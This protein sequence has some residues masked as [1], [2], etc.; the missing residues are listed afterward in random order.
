MPL[1]T[2]AQR[3]DL[4]E[5][6]LRVAVLLVAC[7]LVLANCA[8]QATVATSQAQIPA[9]APGSARVWFF[10]GWDA[11]SGQSFVYGAAPTIYANGVPV[12]EI[13]TGTAFF[14]DFPPGTHSFTVELP[15][16]PVGSQLAVRLSRGGFQFRT[17]YLRCADGIAASGS[18]I[19]AHLDLSRPALVRSRCQSA[20]KTEAE[21]SLRVTAGSRRRFGGLPTDTIVLDSPLLYGNVRLLSAS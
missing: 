3:I 14:R 6:A 19:S 17:Q 7:V 18:G 4:S 15:S 2:A 12:G 11:P 13:R 5:Y 21:N 16:D 8:P 1:N 10:R 20:A 9:I